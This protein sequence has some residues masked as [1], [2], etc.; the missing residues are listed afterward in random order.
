MGVP[1]V[2]KMTL[3]IGKGKIMQDRDSD[4]IRIVGNKMGN[5]ISCDQTNINKI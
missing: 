1:K 2:I 5:G 4:Q 3:V